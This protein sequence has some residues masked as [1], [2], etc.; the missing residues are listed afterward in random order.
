[1]AN[2]PSGCFSFAS[3][4]SMP[5]SRARHGMV[6]KGPDPMPLRSLRSSIA[7]FPPSRCP[8]AHVHMRTARASLPSRI[9]PARI[10]TSFLRGRA[11]S[12]HSSLSLTSLTRLSP[13][14]HLSQLNYP[15][16]CPLSTLSRYRPAFPCP[17]H[18]TPP[19]RSVFPVS[20][21][22]DY[23]QPTRIPHSPASWQAGPGLELLPPHVG[24][25]ARGPGAA[26]CT[27]EPTGRG[28][29]TGRGRAGGRATRVGR[30]RPACSKR[31]E[32]GDV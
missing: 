16:L 8:L 2:G 19:Q 22:A 29:Q 1:M 26:P 20:S 6:T 25:R 7:L 17:P 5:P 21:P 27:C 28:E 31:G 24:P 14:S 3:S 10:V 12:P 15:R 23:P 13:L 18:P 30:E 4:A 32:G 9:R 11:L